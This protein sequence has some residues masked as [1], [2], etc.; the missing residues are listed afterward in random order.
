M[1]ET[2]EPGGTELRSVWISAAE[3]LRRATSSAPGI[4][5]NFLGFE[6]MALAIP[7][8]EWTEK[9]NYFERNVETKSV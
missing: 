4:V 2:V 6:P 3:S 9:E 7:S 8:P 1:W 5:F